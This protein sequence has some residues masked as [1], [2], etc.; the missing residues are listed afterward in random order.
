MQHKNRDDHINTI[1]THGV[2]TDVN[3]N[4]KIIF[5]I[6]IAIIISGCI[7]SSKPQ[8][9]VNEEDQNNIIILN[10]DHTALLKDPHGYNFAGKYS[11]DD[12]KITITWDFMGLVELY[13]ISNN[14]LVG[15]EPKKIVWVLSN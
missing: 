9:Y 1:E 10:P 14:T 12:N 11:K 15:P 2:G 7:G 3:N 13:T 4:V 6:V 5:V 8:K